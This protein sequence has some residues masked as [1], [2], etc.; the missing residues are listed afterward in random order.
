MG[1]LDLLNPDGRRYRQELKEQAREYRQEAKEILS[2]AKDLYDD[3]KDVR[4]EARRAA[5]E[6]ESMLK[7]HNNYKAD[8]LRELGNDINVSIENFRRFNINSRITSPPNIDTSAPIIPSIIS[9]F[10]AITTPFNPVSIAF[11][12]FSDP[13]RDRDEASRQKDAAQEY[14]WKVKDALQDVQCLYES[15]NNSRKYI[16]DEKSN[17]TQLMEKVRNIVGQLNAA[18]NRNSFTDKE[19]RYMTGISKIA[20]KIKN[21]LEQRILNGSGNIE[22]NYKLYSG[23]IKEI[24]KLIPSSPTISSSSDWVERLL[25]Y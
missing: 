5:N 12:V 18:M 16:E 8:I 25:T 10:N 9:G 22:N 1:F 20:E 21:S 2:D 17:L 15:L 11:S 14:Y 19:A 13:E 23:K 6:L 3:Y 7:N 4:G 24:N